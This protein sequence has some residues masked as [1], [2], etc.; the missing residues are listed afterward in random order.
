MDNAREREAALLTYAMTVA[1][2]VRG[3]KS[4]D[5]L[6][7]RLM[8][9]IRADAVS[10]AADLGRLLAVQ[11]VRVVEHRARERDVVGQIARGVEGFI[12]RLGR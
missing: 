4:V 12:A 7:G 3:F 9:C 8:G 6:V 11:A 5:D 2:Q 1:Q 10:V